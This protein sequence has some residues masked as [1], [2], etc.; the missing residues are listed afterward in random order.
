MVCALI[1]YSLGRF[2]TFGNNSL[3]DHS[4]YT[5]WRS[6]LA[7]AA[8]ISDTSSAICLSRCRADKRFSVPSSQ[9]NS[10]MGATGFRRYP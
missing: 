7:Q 4:L 2:G 8:E 3:T 1:L 6:D 10:T 5:F 9:F